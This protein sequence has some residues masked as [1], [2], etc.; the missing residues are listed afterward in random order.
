MVPELV[1]GSRGDCLGGEGAGRHRGLLLRLLFDLSI[2]Q[3]FDRLK[4]S[5]AP[6]TARSGT[7]R[8]VREP[9]PDVIQGR[10][11]EEPPESRGPARCAASSSFMGLLPFQKEHT[12]SR[13]ATRA[14]H[15]GSI[16]NTPVDGA[17]LSLPWRCYAILSGRH[18]HCKPRPQSVQVLDTIRFSS[19]FRLHRRHRSIH[20]FPVSPAGGR[21]DLPHP[22]RPPLLSLSYRSPSRVP[23]LPGGAAFPSS[24]LR[25]NANVARCGSSGLQRAIGIGAVPS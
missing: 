4:T 2:L 21:S 18:S 13:R 6:G 20:S 8:R 1:E 10:G 19:Y 11:S 5:Q 7:T 24:R 23:L 3:P 12:V 25:L 9:A 17:S 15:T 22:L 14:T 16:E